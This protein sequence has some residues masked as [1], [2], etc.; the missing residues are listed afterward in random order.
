MIGISNPAL[1]GYRTGKWLTDWFSSARDSIRNVQSTLDGI[2]G[3][4]IDVQQDANGN[5]YSTG[6]SRDGA[7]ALFPG[8][9]GLIG[10]GDDIPPNS[11]NY[12]APQTP[13]QIQY[14]DAP[15][16][17]M[18]GM[19]AETAY[20][21]ALANSAYQRKVADLKAAGLNPVL[22]INGS[23][24][25]SFGGSF[26]SYGSAGSGKSTSDLSGLLGK[27]SYGLPTFVNGLVN[28]AV[29]L[30]T[31]NGMSGFGAGMMAQ[32]ITQGALNLGKNFS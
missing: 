3:P 19:S 32:N 16:A 14:F 22:G 10:V 31:G 12:I 28:L 9:S 1:S 5:W 13:Q 23:G 29:T 25:A 18:Y 6:A 30:K 11:G 17:E 4:S 26:A 21:E 20:Q 24:A 2:S 27:L 15:Y 8:L 7:A